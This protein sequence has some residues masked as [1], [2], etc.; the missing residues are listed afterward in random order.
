MHSLNLICCS[1]CLCCGPSAFLIPASHITERKSIRSCEKKAVIRKRRRR[2]RSH[3]SH[4]THSPYKFAS[5]QQ[6]ASNLLPSTHTSL[7]SSQI[8]LSCIRNDA[9]TNTLN[10]AHRYTHGDT[11]TQQPGKP[12]NQ[13]RLLSWCDAVEA[14]RALDSSPRRRSECLTNAISAEV[15][16]RLTASQQQHL[17]HHRQTHTRV[18]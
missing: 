15:G 17:H 18:H 16:R 1:E 4:K 14:M 9:R 2:C 7:S 3:H 11:H 5:Q 8:G 12:V 13:A 6:P 10:F